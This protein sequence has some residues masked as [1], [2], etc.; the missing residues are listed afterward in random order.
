MNQGHELENKPVVVR[1][2]MKN[3]R[4][5]KTERM[6]RAQAEMLVRELA[7]RFEKV[8]FEVG[9]FEGGVARFLG[10]RGGKA[11]AAA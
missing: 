8:A 11:P 1:W 7:G 3:G 10:A 4:S 9:R 6:P 5:G 2:R